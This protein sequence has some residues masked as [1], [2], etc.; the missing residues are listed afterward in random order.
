MRK[1][2]LGVA[3]LLVS[4]ALA[5]AGEGLGLKVDVGLDVGVVE[6]VKIIQDRGSDIE[7]SSMALVPSLTVT[8]QFTDEWS[9]SLWLRYLAGFDDDSADAFGDEATLSISGFDIGGLAGYTFKLSDRFAVT[10]VAGLSWRS[11]SVDLEENGGSGEANEDCS[12]LVLDLGAR[13]A[14]RATDRLNVN[15]GLMFGLG[16]S[17]SAEFGPGSSG[18]DGDLEGLGLLMEFKGGLEYKLTDTISL[19]GGLAYETTS[20]TWDWEYSGEA[21]DDLS[22]FSIQL[23]AAFRF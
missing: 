19:T 11:W 4:G 8:K 16:I 1:I 6:S 7:G 20:V 3:A 23:G 21:D 9:A 22:R 2:L 12:L 15:F 14:Y 10:P 13:A 18:I 5:M 17:G